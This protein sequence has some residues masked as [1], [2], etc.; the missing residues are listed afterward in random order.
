MNRLF[1]TPDQAG[2]SKVAAA[3][4]TLTGINPD[5]EI[6]AHNSNITTMDNFDHFMGRI[7]KGGIDGNRVD[8]VLSC[9]DNY[10]ARVAINSV[11][12]ELGMDWMESGVA[13]NAVSG[14]IQL[15]KPGRTACFL[16]NILP[17]FFLTISNTL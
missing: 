6:E 14:H 4:A 9:V 15:L 12:N 1:F 8:L 10:E 11:C 3:A 13:E 17:T 7:E 5:V 2:L 16:V